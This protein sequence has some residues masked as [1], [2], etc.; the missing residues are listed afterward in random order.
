MPD[1]EE[2]EDEEEEEEENEEE[3]SNNEN[4]EPKTYVKTLSK[5]ARLQ[6]YLQIIEHSHVLY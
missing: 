1:D 3:V 6:K 4:E 5:K 2:D